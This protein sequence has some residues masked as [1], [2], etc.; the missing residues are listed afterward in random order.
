[1]SL[2]GQVGNLPG[3]LALAKG[4]IAGETKQAIENIKTTLE[5]HAYEMSDLVKCTVFLA[6]IAEWDNF[7][8]VYLTYFGPGQFPARC[9]F[10]SADLVVHARVEVD[11][12]NAK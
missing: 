2:S 4:G 8:K 3:T 9:A 1:L 7:N 6:D 10:G 11:C 12:T 5:A